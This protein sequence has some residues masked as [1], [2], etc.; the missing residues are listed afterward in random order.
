VGVRREEWD[1]GNLLKSA[2][3]PGTKCT[4]NIFNVYIV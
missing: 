4:K 3:I 1:I 2:T